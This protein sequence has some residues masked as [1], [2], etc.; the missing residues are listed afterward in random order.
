MHY[1]ISSR[2][3]AVVGTILIYLSQFA[4]AA[5]LI[6]I[7]QTCDKTQAS[8][9]GNETFTYSLRYSNSSLTT[10]VTGGVIEDL[11]NANLDFVAIST[12]T[13]VLNSNFDAATR[14]VTVN[15]KS[16]LEPGAVGSIG[17]TVK[18]KNTVT[19]AI[20]VSNN[21]TARG[22]NSDLQTSNSVSV[23]ATNPASAGSG[24]LV[25][26][27]KTLVS[28]SADRTSTSQNNGW[29][30]YTLNHGIT[31]PAGA[32]VYDYCVWDTFPQGV[33]LVAIAPE[34][35][36]SGVANANVFY[37]T[38]FNTS[39][40]AW[41]GNP[42]WNT[43]SSNSDWIGVWELG[44]PAGEWVTGIEVHYSPL[45]GGGAFHPSNMTR[46]LT[47]YTTVQ[48]GAAV[49]E[50]TVATNCGF[51]A[52][53]GT[54]VA[55]NCVNT[56]ISK[57]K[58]ELHT[59]FS[60]PSGY[61]PP[62]A[63]NTP[64][65]LG[66]TL[67]LD[68]SSIGGIVN[69]KLGLI[70]PPSFEFL[71]FDSVEGAKWAAAGSPQPIVET[72]PNFANNGSTL[73]RFLWGPSNPFTMTPTSTSW[74]NVSVIVN[75]KAKPT[76]V[77]G[78]YDFD[79][80]V[81]MQTTYTQT[82]T[83]TG[84]CTSSVF[85]NY[86]V[87][88]RNN[89]STNS[90][91]EGRMLTRNYTGTA[92]AT[93]GMNLSGWPS[94]NQSLQI[95][96]SLAAGSPLNLQYGSLFLPSTS[97]LNGRVINYNG[98]GTRQTASGPDFAGIFGGIQLASGLYRLQAAN[99]T[100]SIPTSP[101]GVVLQV[102]SNLGTGNTAV[103]NVDGNSLLS[104]SNVQQI[105]INLNGKNPNAI[106][107]NCSGGNVTLS[108]NFV[109]NFTSTGL[110]NRIL[111]H[112]PDAT[113]VNLNTS[114][115][116]SILAPNA[117]VNAN[118]GA[119]EGSVYANNL[120]AQIEVHLPVF[121][122]IL[123]PSNSTST[124]IVE[125]GVPYL[126]WKDADNLDWNSNGNTTE[127]VGLSRTQI[128]ILTAGGQPALTAVMS[129]K[130]EL[131]PTPKVAPA[132][133]LTTASGSAEYNLRFTNEA[134]V[135]M[136]NL[137]I[138]NILPHIGDRGVIDL[139]TRGSTYSPYLASPINA[140]GA[141]TY[142]STAGN[143]CRNELTP[144]IP[145]G[146]VLPNW[147][148]VPPA[149]LSTI[150]SIKLDFGN[151]LI[152]PS[153]VLTMTWPMR[154]PINAPTATT[155]VAWN[156][157]GYSVTRADNDVKMLPSEPRMTGVKVQAPVPPFYGDRVWLDANN[158]G[159]QDAG[160][161]GINGIRLD[162][163]RDNGDNVRDVA[164]DTFVKFTTT[165][166]GGLYRFANMGAG[167]YYAVA[168][169]P[170]TYGISPVNQGT[171]DA[172]DSDGEATQIGGGRTGLMPITNLIVGESDLT[173][174][175]GLYDR[176]S[177]PAVW[178]SLP[179]SNGS[180]Y[181]GGRFSKAATVSRK[182]I[183]R[184][185]STGSVDTGFNPG[186]GFNND[187]ISLTALG[188]GTIVAGGIFT[189]YN[190]GAANGLAMLSASGPAAGAVPQPD[191]PDVR[192]VH[193]SGSQVYFAGKF[194]K[195]NNQDYDCVARMSTNGTLDTTFNTANGA[196][197]AI[198]D[199]AVLPDGSIILGGKFTTWGGQARAGVVK[200][201]SNGALATNFNIGSGA[202][203]EVRSVKV[204]TDGR[205]VLSGRFTTFNNVQ[206]R[207]TI[208]LEPSGAVD[209]SMQ[210]NDLDVQSINSIN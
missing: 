94:G 46:G 41:P 25:F 103:F 70:V 157:F 26:D 42:R 60:W 192:W 86:N 201:N 69:P 17:I 95:Q 83:T 129:V 36:A 167:N 57:A 23:T 156:S 64:F 71:G 24:T 21:A 135:A 176:S 131:D 118:G 122:G 178:A 90:D 207:G 111:W 105:D 40:R 73:V 119:V 147:T 120:N 130:G 84:A 108:A 204:L 172:I 59:Y 165:A 6:R 182:N 2:L 44:L 100:A 58:P 180:L 35:F 56:T 54:G 88:T 53:S 148:N 18:F 205:I 189:S 169:V 185:S 141:T 66:M 126:G 101:A 96:N 200:I 4:G 197:D 164:T 134:G 87:I 199:G 80:Y 33:G 8:V 19:S 45:A 124:T 61:Y 98:G 30:T 154:V 117:T 67:G 20:T 3:R 107:I 7:D 110:R 51:S 121:T 72:V 195:V 29:L 209:G 136:K 79:G 49:P 63:T 13:H 150:K 28:K 160:E 99:S 31:H 128:Q 93:L 11:L 116:G 139:S 202:N 92:S 9:Q 10:S 5:V 91:I 132:T 159:L 145:V 104:N 190:G 75:L 152:L 163:Y 177:T 109:G 140:P 62:F 191:T 193:A 27:S 97:S 38:N 14:K 55:T 68:Q 52:G 22:A 206:C 179:N 15:F 161:V 114:L 146:C 115:Y 50:D 106:L 138:I 43:S 133:A 143:P 65:K 186:T 39:L 175:L 210:M 166:S 47:L 196:N 89:L 158:N 142:Y 81:D 48:A 183:A 112:F 149:D 74:E 85:Q 153:E 203:N 198:N 113:V 37:R 174:D 188:N 125:N 12:T 127:L 77:N 170:T 173:W 168:Q 194:F 137:V 151:T 82:T 102:G 181:I 32:T 155:D 208:R 78:W 16:P 171:N 187:V 162:L 34:R 123:C 184:L 144:G 1:S 76:T